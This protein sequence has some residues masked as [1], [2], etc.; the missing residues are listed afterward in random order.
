MKPASNRNKRR[1]IAAFVIIGVLCVALTF[2]IGWIQII[3][4]DYYSQMAVERQTQD[5]PIAA[6][7]GIIYDRNGKELAI[8]ATSHTVWAW[9]KN[10]KSAKTSEEGQ[11]KLDKAVDALSEILEMEK[12]EV[13]DLLTQ[14]KS[15]IK[16]AKYVNKE[17]ADLIREKQ[18][19]G[20]SIA[21]DVKRYYPEG[22]FAAHILGSTTDDNRGLAGIELKYDNYLSGLPGRWIKNTDVAGK[23]LTY[24]VEKYFK[25]EDGLSV[26]LTIDEVIQHYVEKSLVQ[27]QKNTKAKR[28][29]CVAMNPKTAEVLAMAAIPEYDPNNPR[30]PLDQALAEEMEEMSGEEK[31][32]IWNEM[33]RNPIVSDTYEPGSTFKLITTAA[34]LD[35]GVTNP[36]EGFHCSGTYKVAD[37]LLKCWRFPNAHGSETLTQA[38]QNSCNPVFIQLAQRMGKDKFYSYLE[39]FGLMEK[40]GIDFPGEGENL[41][42]AKSVVGPVELA[43]ISYGQ[44]IAVTPISLIT[45]ISAL[46]N[47]GVLMEPRLVKALLDKDGNV[48]E[49]FEPQKVRQV[50]SKQTA[51]EM[52]MIME[53]VVSEGGG[54]TAKI[55]GYRIGG[56]T[57]TA[58]KAV[59]G[60]YSNDKFSSFIGM[61]PM[62]DPQ[63]AIL[64]V[65]DTPQGVG[66]GSQTAAPGVKAILEDTLR[67]MN[68][69][70][71]YTDQEKAA[72]KSGMVAVP[73]VTNSSFGEAIGILGGV[74]LKYIVSPA[75]GNKEDFPIIDQYPKA[76]EKVKEGTTVY[77]YKK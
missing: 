27:V 33:W 8:S 42:Q 48:V 45:A 24:G 66:F 75:P 11:K 41:L 30:V 46:G 54:G 58:N 39:R 57:G 32:R 22:A 25:A 5:T 9:P 15:L 31:V 12:E 49:S 73:N 3:K 29:I 74:G 19:S 26:M 23:S 70:P 7:R 38:V 56:K 21:E 37:R 6:A 13:R 40:T 44:G 55:P 69:A 61:A 47:E 10:V 62:D 28:V 68:V 67:Y 1:L 65:V 63:I 14:Q 59:G 17:K 77:L 43:T 16:V 18:L 53:S 2:R 71:N 72:M 34:A 64:L 51:E 36:S 52:C 4:S 35:D 76:G 50:V 20:I 60:G